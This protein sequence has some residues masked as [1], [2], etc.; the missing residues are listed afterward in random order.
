M[1]LVNGKKSTKALHDSIFLLGDEDSPQVIQ[2]SVFPPTRYQGS[3]YKLIKWFLSIFKKYKFKTVLDAFG[4]TGVVSHMF[5]RMEKEVTY[6][7]LLVS[8]YFIGKALIENSGIITNV[9]DVVHIFKRHKAQKY[10][11]I[12]QDNFRDIYYTDEENKFL[13]IC[14]QNIIKSRDEYKKALYFFSL[15]QACLQKRP[16]NLFHRKNL[17]LRQRNVKRSFG[18]KKTWDTPF[19]ELFMKALKQANKAIFDN[20]QNNK[21]LNYPIHDLL[22]PEEGFD[23]IYLDPPYISHTGVGVNYRDFYHFLEG[24]CNY[25]HWLEMIDFQSKHRRL[26]VHKNGWI[27]KNQVESEFESVVAKFQ[28][29][30]ISISY[31]DPGIPPI[32]TIQDI[33]S[34]YKNV[35]D[36]YTKGYSYALTSRKNRGREILI[37]GR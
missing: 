1:E 35:V 14:V 15:F 29:S 5:K 37:I 25:H 28:D 21:A 2:T 3:K 32:P 17:Y 18:N 33:V 7:D 10:K 34:T 9:S 20:N 4:G 30:I 8:N 31:R 19:E 12:I 6:N 22:L 26:K 23:L 13:D 36:T 16:F 24:I 27:N 11:T